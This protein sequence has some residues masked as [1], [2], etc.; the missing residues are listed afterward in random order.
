MCLGQIGQ[1]QLQGVT[2]FSVLL[3]RCLRAFKLKYLGAHIERLLLL[4]DD[5]HM[6]EEITRFP[7]GLGMDG[8]VAP[9]HRPGG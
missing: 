7:L 8:G 9:E 6:R 1:D 3:G 5:K 2:A 4:A